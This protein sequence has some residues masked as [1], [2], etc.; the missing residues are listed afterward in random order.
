MKRVMLL[1]CLCLVGC[2]PQFTDDG[3]AG[4]KTQI[5]DDLSAKGLEVHEVQLVKVERRKLTGFAKVSKIG[6][7]QNVTLTCD[8][9]MDEKTTNFIWSCNR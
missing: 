7:E 4:V 5:K 3:V 9:T 8:A 2:G 1:V 6:G